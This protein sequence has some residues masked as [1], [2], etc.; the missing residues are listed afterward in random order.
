MDKSEQVLVRMNDLLAAWQA[1]NDRRLI[2]LDCYIMMTRNVLE[3][4]QADAFEDTPWVATLMENFAG[5]YFQALEAYE[6]ESSSPPEVWGIA[7]QAAKH[8]HVH[9]VQSL[10]LGVNAHINYD[11]VFALSDLLASEWAQVSPEQR[12]LRYRDYC[13][14]NH[15]INNTIDAVRNQII[16]RYD[17][18]IGEADKL[19]GPID[20][21]MT[22]LLLSEWREEVWKHATRLLDPA[23]TGDRAAIIQQ[24]HKLALDRA[25]DILGKGSL[26]ALAE[27]I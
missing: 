6:N 25:E 26:T 14:I 4:I 15:I 16:D 27:F 21:W 13:Q 19:L 8:P 3:A 12:Q 20:R 23:E 17:P 24:V 18:L 1:A 9:A 2:F 22:S 7:F 11:L 10:V 5:L